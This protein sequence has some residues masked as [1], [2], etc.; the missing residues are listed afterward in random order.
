V[1][2]RAR[3]RA[4]RTPR[5]QG[6]PG[7]PREGKARRQ[8]ILLWG[9]GGRQ[10]T[11]RSSGSHGHYPAY[12]CGMEAQAYGGAYGQAVRG[13]GLEAAVARLVLEALAPERLALALAACEPL[14]REVEALERPWQ[15]R[16]E[17]V[18]VEAH[19]AYRQDDAVEPANRL[20]ARALEAQWDEKRRAVELAE[21]D[22]ATWKQE[23]R[24]ALSAH[25]RAEILAIGEDLP[26]VWYGTG[27]K[28]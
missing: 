9:G 24:T 16:R 26:R 25:E 12:R 10:M 3:L 7:V 21:R 28:F 1:A 6:S 4:N 15:L 2:N 11:V 18:R 8:G 13:L 20:V 5:G 14:E 22:D 23:N 27:C 19:R 17:R